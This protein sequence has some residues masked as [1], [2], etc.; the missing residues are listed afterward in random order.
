MK[1][2]HLIAD[3]F[4]KAFKGIEIPKSMIGV[5][6]AM[7]VC[8]DTCTKITSFDETVWSI[9][10]DYL[11]NGGVVADEDYFL[12]ACALLEGRKETIQ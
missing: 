2:Y 7:K 10:Q 6:R 4:E 8:P 5:I 12:H 3:S 9:I 11:N 1:Q